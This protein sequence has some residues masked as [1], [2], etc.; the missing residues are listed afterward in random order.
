MKT[1]FTETEILALL[2]PMTRDLMADSILLD[3]YKP[4]PE[5]FTNLVESITKTFDLGYNQG[6]IQAK[7][8]MMNKLVEFFKVEEKS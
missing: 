4:K 3:V 8:D 5:D 7:L 1:N 2:R 6:M